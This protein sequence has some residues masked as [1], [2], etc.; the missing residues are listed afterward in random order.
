MLPRALLAALA[1]ARL[2][3][4]SYPHVVGL[5]AG[6]KFREGKRLSSLAVQFFVDRKVARPTRRLPRFLLG[7][8]RRGGIVP[9]RRIPTQGIPGSPP[10]F[11]WGASRALPPAARRRRP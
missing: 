6:F 2:R 8:D 3:Y 9:R 11:A 1:A 10:R 5:A 7:R 4:R